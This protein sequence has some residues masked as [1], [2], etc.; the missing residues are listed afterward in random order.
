MYSFR[1]EQ[2]IRAAAV[3]H[4]DQVRKGTMPFP[5]ITHLV[6]V[7]MSLCAYTAD[8]DVI[9]AAFLHDTIEDTD[10]TL[11][12]LEQDF[13]PTV[14]D[15][16]AT[17]SEPRSDTSSDTLTWQERKRTYRTQLQSAS[18]EAL[19]VAAADKI[20]NMRTVVETYFDEPLKFKQDFGG[21]LKD[22]MEHYQFLANIF[23]RALTNDI[24]HEFNHVFSEYRDFIRNI[25]SLNTQ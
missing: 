6:S 21:T 16:V 25:E 13:G 10:Y 20:H 7:A 9:V 4:R 24:L 8:E 17:V 18:Q 15:I 22:R 19:L 2:A 14:R 1:V 12:E 3:L 11:E 5:Y 23:N